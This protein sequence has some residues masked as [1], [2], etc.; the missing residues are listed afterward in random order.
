MV[1]SLMTLKQTAW[2]PGGSPTW[3]VGRRAGVGLVA[4][5][6]LR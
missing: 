3:G 5:S 6:G 4:F 1:S 2:N